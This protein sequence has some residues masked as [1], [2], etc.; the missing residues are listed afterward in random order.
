MDRL[1]ITQLIKMI[2]TCYKNCDSATATYRALKV[3][4][5]LH[6][7]P[8]PQAFGKIG[9]VTNIGSPV[10]HRFARSAENIAII[11]ESAAED[12]NVSI[13]FQGIGLSYITLW[14]IMHLDL[15]LHP[16]KVQL[17]Q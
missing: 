16:Y 11:S 17:T 9:V 2:K 4:Y 8:S 10:H 13:R 3:N 5:S 12:Q 15:H 1:T 6:N 7:R 14:R